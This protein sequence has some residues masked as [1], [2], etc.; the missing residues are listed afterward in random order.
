[1]INGRYHPYDEQLGYKTVHADIVTENELKTIPNLLVENV[2]WR[3]E[4][5]YRGFLVIE[6]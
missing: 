4:I 1:M 3:A 5:N 6:K 2:R